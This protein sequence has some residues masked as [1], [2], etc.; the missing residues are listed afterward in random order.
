MDRS[1][2]FANALPLATDLLTEFTEMSS[3]VESPVMLIPNAST[4]Q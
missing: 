2:V 1:C 4:A 3:R